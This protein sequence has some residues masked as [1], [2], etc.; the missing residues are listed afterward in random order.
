MVASILRL[1]AIACFA[2]IIPNAITSHAQE[3]PPPLPHAFYGAVQ[4][5]GKPAPVGTRIE[6]RGVGVL[7]G[8]ENNPVS[9]IEQ[10]RYGGRTSTVPKLVVQ[11]DVQEDAAMAFYINGIRAEVAV[12]GGS[13]Q[14]TYPF[15]SGAITELNLRATIYSLYLP[16]I[17][18]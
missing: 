18:G 6:A 12:P 8:I 14:Q 15:S 2:S 16:Y 5:N 1:V 3:T 13:W 9:V 10:G 7:T 11:G 4:I 17:R